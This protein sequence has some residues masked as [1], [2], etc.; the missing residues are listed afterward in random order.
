MAITNREINANFNYTCLLLDSLYN[1]AI[2]DKL[3]DD[4]LIAV[5]LISKYN[6]SIYKKINNLNI[7]ICIN[8]NILNNTYYFGTYDNISNIGYLDKNYLEHIIDKHNIFLIKQ[9]EGIIM[10]HNNMSYQ[11]M[12]DIACHL[13]I[14]RVMF[15]INF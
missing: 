6:I 8:E 3:S 2:N 10:S 7:L 14:G 5:D 13:K 12:S 11:E 1:K 4:E 15:V 9:N